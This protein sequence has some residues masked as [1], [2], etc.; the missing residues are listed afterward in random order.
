MSCICPNCGFAMAYDD[1]RDAWRCGRCN[2]V[3]PNESNCPAPGTDV[4]WWTD[5]ERMRYYGIGEYSTMTAAKRIVAKYQKKKEVPKA[6][7]KGT[8]TVYEYS[9]GQI[10]KRNKDK[11]DRLHKLGGNIEKL[12]TQVKKDLTNKD[13]KVA[14]TALAVAL[15]DA[16]AERVGS[17]ASAAGDLNDKG[18]AHFG[19]TTWKTKHITFK[20]SSATIKYTGK[21]GV[22]HEKKVTDS[23]IVSALKKAH[24]NCKDGSVF[25]TEDGKITGTTVNEYLKDFDITAK[26][27]RGYHANNDMREALKAV[28]SKGGKL[29]TDKKERE[30]QLKDEFKEALEAV[31]DDVGHEPSTLKNQYLTPGLEDKFLASGEVMKGMK[32]AKLISRFLAGAR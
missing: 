31:A 26:D 1:G 3:G 8:T 30:K 19:V 5:E 27:L 7:G 28:R 16:T 18:E 20:G 6:N 32:E 14:L 24:E 4:K 12:R 17:E 21:S 22:K 10:A 23:A 9:E 15:M 25:C 11:A 2:F 29:P 13:P